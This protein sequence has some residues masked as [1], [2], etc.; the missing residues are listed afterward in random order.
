MNRDQLDQA[1]ADAARAR[2]ALDDFAATAAKSSELSRT[3]R[4]REIWDAVACRLREIAEELP[5][6]G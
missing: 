5:E 4:E 2:R 1:H 3:S 6:A